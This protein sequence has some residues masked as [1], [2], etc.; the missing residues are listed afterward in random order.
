MFYSIPQE[1]FLAKNIDLIYFYKQI[2][3]K[4]HLHSQNN[5]LIN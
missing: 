4:Y 3:Y 5:A 1:S 2:P